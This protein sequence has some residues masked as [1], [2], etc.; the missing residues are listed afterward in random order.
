MS[1]PEQ[2]VGAILLNV[3]SNTIT[4]LVTA[5]DGTTTNTYTLVITRA[6]SSNANLSALAL[7]AG[8]QSPVFSPSTTSYTASVGNA[9]S[10]VRLTPTLADTTAMLKVN[11]WFRHPG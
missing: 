7:S 2:L 6:P 1:F 10:A 11:R 4:V 3:G 5:Q 8:T 9:V